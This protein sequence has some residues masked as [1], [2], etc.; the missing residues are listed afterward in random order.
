[1]ERKILMKRNICLLLLVFGFINLN[2]QT[3]DSFY[4]PSK[5]FKFSEKKYKTIN[6]T[7]V[8][9]KDG[10][11]LEVIEKNQVFGS[12]K[13]AYVEQIINWERNL[14]EYVIGYGEDGWISTD[15][16]VLANSEVF[17]NSIVTMN[18][19]M[20]EKK[21][22]PIW[23][24]NIL[25]KE[26]K[27]EKIS[28]YY[29]EYKDSVMAYV[30][31][32]L[33][34]IE[35]K[36][37]NLVFNHTSD[38]C[39]FSIKKI[40]KKGAVYYIDSEIEKSGQSYFND[41]YKNESFENLP[42]L[43]EKRDTTFIIEQNGN[44]LRVYNGEN[45]KLII[46]LMPINK[47]WADKMIEYIESDYNYIPSGLNPIEEK[48]DHP[49]SDPKTGLYEGNSGNISNKTV[50]TTTITPSQT[51]SVSENL[52]LR[53]AEA[54][55]SKVLTVMAAG[56]KVKILELG[57]S[58]TIDGITSNWV[59]VEVQADAKDRDGKPIKAGTV[60]W[61]YGGYL[62]E[63]KQNDEKQAVKKDVKKRRKNDR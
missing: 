56:T 9:D 8:Y 31:G 24:N 46:E 2:S 35:F 50:T 45:Y 16:L 18:K 49:W 11:V 40:Q 33:H 5:Y 57:H 27:F 10:K 34:E 25:S 48:L 54:T 1:M 26:I 63:T 6:K 43:T 42:D 55:T 32:Q 19:I 39:Y 36:N 12:S 14:F 20:T 51:M 44:R 58:E 37:T 13:F 61:C 17:P 52:K 53:S 47:E 38:S 4:E 15:D 22:I 28:N 29:L 23:Y 21:W 60:G 62:E 7:N 59:K 41:L 3:W 30:F